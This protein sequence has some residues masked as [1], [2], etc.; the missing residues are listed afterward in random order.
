MPNIFGA[1]P[2]L[3]GPALP[4]CEGFAPILLLAL[5]GAWAVCLLEAPWIFLDEALPG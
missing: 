5:L 3:V 2:N 1:F 4:V